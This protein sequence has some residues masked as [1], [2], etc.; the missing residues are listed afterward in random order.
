ML[1][2]EYL[3]NNPPVERVEVDY[4]EVSDYSEKSNVNEVEK[5]RNHSIF[6]IAEFIAK[7]SFVDVNNENS[8]EPTITSY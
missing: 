6:G 1:Q 2:Q 3:I 7:N 8:G 5:S 4:L